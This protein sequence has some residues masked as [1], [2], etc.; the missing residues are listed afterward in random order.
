MKQ[1]TRDE[2]IKMVERNG[3]HYDRNNGSHSIY[4][5]D[6][7]HITIPLRI[8]APIAKRLIKEHNLNINL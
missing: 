3:Y 6:G 1:W 2:F 5:K 7:K 4:V 8:E